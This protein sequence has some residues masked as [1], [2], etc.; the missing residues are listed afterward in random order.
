MTHLKMA[1]AQ[2]A[3]HTAQAGA[4]SQTRGLLRRSSGSGGSTAQQ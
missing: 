1:V 3:Q 2:L 4:L